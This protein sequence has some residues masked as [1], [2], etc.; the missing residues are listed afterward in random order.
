MS[1][2]SRSGTAATS[3]IGSTISGSRRAASGSGTCWRPGH[4]P[5]R[6]CARWPWSALG[7]GR[8]TAS[9]HGSAM[10]WP[11]G[12]T[13][14][15]SSSVCRCDTP[16]RNASQP[17]R[18]AGGW[19]GRSARAYASAPGRNPLPVQRPIAPEQLP[20]PDRGHQPFQVA[21]VNRHRGCRVQTSGT[22]LR[23]DRLAR[24][25]HGFRVN[26]RRVRL[27][28]TPY[29]GQTTKPRHAKR[30]KPREAPSENPTD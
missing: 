7:G 6:G 18:R 16:R 15:F 10:T 30:S 28:E 25:L 27:P 21:R 20:P 11:R 23:R 5:R 4:R 9:H 2:A 8:C 14:R 17:V 26:L 19:R 24:L 29:A 12:P 3:A 1:N 13:G 22:T